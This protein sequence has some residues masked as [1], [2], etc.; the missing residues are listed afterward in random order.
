MSVSAEFVKCA[1]VAVL[2]SQCSAGRAS[3][4][5]GIAGKFDALESTSS[6]QMEIKKN[7]ST[8]YS[9]GD[10]DVEIE[11]TT[12]Q[13]IQHRF[14][15]KI[16]RNLR[17]TWV[18]YRPRLENVDYWFI[19]SNE[20]ESGKNKNKLSTI[21]LAPKAKEKIDCDDFDGDVHLNGFDIPLLCS[22]KDD[23]YKYFS[24]DD[25]YQSQDDLSVF[26]NVERGVGVTSKM[27]QYFFKGH[28]VAGIFISQVTSN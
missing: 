8:K 3:T 28:S 5:D 11:K 16:K 15:G 22:N 9:S 10:F 1:I 6:R 4:L 2:A 21:I 27:I 17:E 18:C 25:K 19:S 12:I 7:P 13:D 23:I 24:V 20:M 14:G 26:H